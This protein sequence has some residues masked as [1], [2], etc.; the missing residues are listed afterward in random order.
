MLALGALAMAVVPATPVGA[1]EATTTIELKVVGCDG[2]RVQAVQNVDGSLPYTSSSERVRRGHVRFVVP[3]DRT[4][5][6]A[7]IVYAPFDEAAKA[8]FPMVVIVGFRGKA[9]GD[10]VS[11][12]FAAGSHRGSGCWSGTTDSLVTNKLIVTRQHVREPVLGPGTFTVAAG[13]LRSTLPARPYFGTRRAS[14]MH[15]EDPSI[16]R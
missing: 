16:C 6:M 14:E 3:T 1:A 15:V 12:A 9:P 13:H 7:F 4:V 11:D 10:R 8:G 5:Q 2:C